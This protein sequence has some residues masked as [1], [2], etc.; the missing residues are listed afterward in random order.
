[1]KHVTLLIVSTVLAVVVTAVSVQAQPAPQKSNSSGFFLGLGLEGT[2]IATNVSGS[3]STTES[4]PGFGLVL[5]YGFTPQWSLYGQLS[6][7]SIHNASGVGTYGL[8]HFDLGA[9]VHFRTGP[10]TVVPFLQFGLSGRGFSE[11]VVTSGVT[12]TVSANGAGVAF[13]GGLNAHFTPS[14]AFSVALAY[15]VGNFS[16]Y[17]VDNVSV[18]G[19]T[20]SATS[21]RVHFGIIWFPS[22]P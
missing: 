4:G 11:N 2:A 15:S 9:R 19:Q 1:M 5:G 16:S 18:A 20:L 8:G 7:A 21:A 10:N 14:V 13:G 3:P 22:A 6:A 17:Q 12:H